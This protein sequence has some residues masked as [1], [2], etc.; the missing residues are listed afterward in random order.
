LSQT[1]APRPTNPRVRLIMVPVETVAV[2]RFSGTPDNGIAHETELIRTLATTRWQP[3][4]EPYMMFYDAPFTIPALR[5]NEA[6][7]AVE[8][9]H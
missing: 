1:T 7:A 8:Q 2:L 9:R 4:S 6:A 3:T 5:R